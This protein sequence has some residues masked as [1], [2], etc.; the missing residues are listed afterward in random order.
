MILADALLAAK[1]KVGA[2]CG[3][4]LLSASALDSC[5]CPRSQSTDALGWVIH[6][7]AHGLRC[8]GSPAQDVL[9]YVPGHP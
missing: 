2:V 1:D 7:Q 6:C 9:E 4:V 5:S 8:P 3:R